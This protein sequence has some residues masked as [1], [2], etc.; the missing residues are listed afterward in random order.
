VNE[1]YLSFAI[2]AVTAAPVLSVRSHEMAG[3]ATVPES[4][5][6]AARAL[7][8]IVPNATPTTPEKVLASADT[9]T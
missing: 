4:A 6:I 2:P 3:K 7:V 8:G 9:L 1:I 5:G